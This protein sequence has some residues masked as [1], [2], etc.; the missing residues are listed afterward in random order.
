MDTKNSEN[1]AG[2][3]AITDSKIVLRGTS[4]LPKNVTDKHVFDFLTIEV[5][6]EPADSRIVN[7]CCTM[8][9]PFGE[10]ILQ[11]ALIG[12]EVEEGIRNAIEQISTRFFS[13]T[14]KAVIAALRNLSIK[15]VEYLRSNNIVRQ[16]AMH[17]EL[18]IRVKQRTAELANTNEKLEAEALHIS[19]LCTIGEMASGISHELNQPLCAILTHTNVCL[20][21]VKTGIKDIDRFTKNLETIAS[22][23][24]LAGEIIRRIRDFVQKRQPRRTIVDINDI[25]SEVSGFLESDIRHNEI[26][27]ELK[28]A[29]TTPM[30]LANAIQIEQVLMNLMRNSIEAMENIDAQN[31]RLTIHTSLDSGDMLKV[32]VSD[33]GVGP[34]EISGRMFEPFFS[35]KP[36]G[37]GIGLSISHSIIEAHGGTLSAQANSDGGSTFKFTLPIVKENIA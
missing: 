31:R 15:Y 29:E 4:R 36:N 17:D 27:L 34:P 28:P 20:R 26:K 22:Q 10:K 24:K 25:I 21:A 30:V 6:V 1:K 5:E 32:A 35:T 12:Y 2:S 7:L 13:N 18:G 9:L 3:H 23:T 14:R 11:K 33:T 37:L 19:R 8:C 16:K